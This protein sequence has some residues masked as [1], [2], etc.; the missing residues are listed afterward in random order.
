MVSI[1]S[2]VLWFQRS[3]ISAVLWFL[4]NVISA[5]F[6]EVSLVVF[7]GFLEVPLVL[8]Y[9]FSWEQMAERSGKLP[10]TLW[11]MSSILGRFWIFFFNLSNMKLKNPSLYI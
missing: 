5:G 8:F 1:I 3:V 7:Y 11:G 9:G 6:R 10:H 4:R 2:T